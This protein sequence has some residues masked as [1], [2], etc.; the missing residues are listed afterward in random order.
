MFEFEPVPPTT[1]HHADA[2]H[3]ASDHC[4][5]L[6]DEKLLGRSRLVVDQP[7][8]TRTVGLPRG[9]LTPAIAGSSCGTAAPTP[10]CR[11]PRPTQPSPLHGCGGLAHLVQRLRS[12]GVAAAVLGQAHLLAQLLPDVA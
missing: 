2:C 9:A 6:A 5:D 10:P 4:G 3:A 7:P 8:G 1:P 11:P 12:R